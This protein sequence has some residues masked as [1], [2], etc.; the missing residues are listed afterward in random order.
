MFLISD[1]RIFNLKKNSKQVQMDARYL[2]FVFYLKKKSVNIKMA[3]E[4]A[5]M[6]DDRRVTKMFGA[7][8]KKMI[9][10]GNR[11]EEETEEPK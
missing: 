5:G 3:T 1:Q 9:G 2:K 6:T 10:R 4:G 7:V 11:S 8:N